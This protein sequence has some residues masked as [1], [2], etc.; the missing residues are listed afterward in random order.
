MRRKPPSWLFMCIHA[1]TQCYLSISNCLE[2]TT[3]EGIMC[4]I[5]VILYMNTKSSIASTI[6][7]III[8]I[9]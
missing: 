5:Q 1:T 6:D 2:I 9:H 8:R 3:D 4:H 7:F